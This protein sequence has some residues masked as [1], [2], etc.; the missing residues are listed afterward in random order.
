MVS[1]AELQQKIELAEIANERLVK[2]LE[3]TAREVRILERDNRAHR[4]RESHRMQVDLYEQEAKRRAAEHEAKRKRH[5]ELSDGMLRMR[6]ASEWAIVRDERGT[7]LELT[8][9]L[10]A[11]DEPIVHGALPKQYAPTLKGQSVKHS[12]ADEVSRIRR[13]GIGQT[14]F[15]GV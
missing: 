3:R 8:V 2:D 9:P 13:S 7:V 15:V 4:E 6:E 11:D 10:S 12:I 1:K 14:Y 5:Q